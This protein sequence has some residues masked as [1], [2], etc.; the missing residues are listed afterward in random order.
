MSLLELSISINNRRDEDSNIRSQPNYLYLIVEVIVDAVV[1]IVWYYRC[2]RSYS[3]SRCV[4][5]LK[6]M[7]ALYVTP[8]WACCTKKWVRIS[9]GFYW[10]H[11]K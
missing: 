2:N 9:P 7:Q 10:Y 4:S 1:D 6:I 8:A 5:S 3:F 11:Q